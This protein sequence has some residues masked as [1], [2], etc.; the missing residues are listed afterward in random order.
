MAVP[1]EVI[2]VGRV[3]QFK[4]GPRRVIRLSAP[5]GSGFQVNWEYADG[6]QR[7]GRLGGSQWV[8]YFRREAQ[9][10]VMTDAATADG[11]TLLTGAR[12]ACETEVVPVT[13]HTTCPRKWAFVDLET[14]EVWGNDGTGFTRIDAAGA[15]QIAEV[16]HQPKESACPR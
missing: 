16:L 11:R 7:Q 9:G 15:S 4:S 12:V 6:A 2:Q 10:E 1:I 13:L 8:H 3:F 14:G 5:V